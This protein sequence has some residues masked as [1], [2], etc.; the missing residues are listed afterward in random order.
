MTD[1]RVEPIELSLDE[2]HK[3]IRDTK[4]IIIQIY[5]NASGFIWSLQKI[6]DSKYLGRGKFLSDSSKPIRFKSYDDAM[7]NAINNINKSTLEEFRSGISDYDIDWSN[8]ATYIT[9]L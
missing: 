7:S 8:F 1:F 2:Q 6:S 4:D 9:N 5:T 3:H